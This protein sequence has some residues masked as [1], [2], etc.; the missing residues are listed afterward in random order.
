MSR[1][2]ISSRSDDDG[3][4]ARVTAGLNE[5]E[6]RSTDRPTELHP[7][8]QTLKLT[9]PNLPI[10]NSSLCLSLSRKAYL[11]RQSTLHVFL[12]ETG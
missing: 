8:S 12:I 2:W 1:S 5:L 3:S 9:N 4:V 7:N 6:A 11:E 10:R